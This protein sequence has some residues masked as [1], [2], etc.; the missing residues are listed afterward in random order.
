MSPGRLVQGKEGPLDSFPEKWFGRF[1]AIWTGQAFSLVGSQLV[2]FAL[3]WYLTIQTGSA[4]VLAV[5]TMAAMLPQILLSPIAGAYVDRWKRRHV[6]I[7]ADGLVAISTLALVT[8]FALGAA[9]IWEIFVVMFV[10]SCF[11]AFH[12]PASQAAT[13][14]LVPER[15]LARVA[16]FNQS[17]MGFAGILAP[18]LGAV[19]IAFLPMQWVLSVDII[20]AIIAIL[21][22]LAIRFPE[23]AAKVGPAHGVMADMKEGLRFIRSWRGAVL[24]ITSFMVLNM[25]ISPAFSFI[26]ILV[27]DH[28]HG[29][30]IDFASLEVMSGIG[31]IAGGIALGVWGGT[32]RKIVAVMAS[33][34]LAGVAVTLLA[35]VPSNGILLAMVLLLFIGGMMPI[36]NGSVMALMQCSVPPGMQGRVFALLGSLAMAAAPVGLAIGGPVADLVGILPWFIISGVPMVLIGVGS[37]LIPSI[38]NIEDPANCPVVEELEC[39]AP[40]RTSELEPDLEREANSK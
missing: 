24:L 11:T 18:P 22:L 25:L 12:W 10:R 39:K 36:L 6:M 2:Q 29:G 32:K 3:V 28:F 21:P 19:L 17:L 7:A 4:T 9:E 16:G 27:L 34:S 23:P 35:F 33:C 26:P 40:E 14:M 13:T 37:F 5:A 38:M 30:A 31:M 8:L 15:H 20:T 1:F